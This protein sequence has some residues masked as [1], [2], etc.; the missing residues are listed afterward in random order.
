MNHTPV[1]NN[2]RYV[3]IKYEY[4]RTYKWYN[5]HV[6][7]YDVPTTCHVILFRKSTRLKSNHLLAKILYSRVEKKKL[8]FTIYHINNYLFKCQVT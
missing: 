4:S 8:I 3:I 7:M 2:Y 5:M 1:E 6:R